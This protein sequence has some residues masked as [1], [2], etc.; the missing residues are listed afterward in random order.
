MENILEYGV[1]S[2]WTGA[3]VMYLCMAPANKR[4]G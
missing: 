1:L 3:V 2:T 4:K